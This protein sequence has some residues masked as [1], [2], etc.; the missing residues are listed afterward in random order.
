VVRNKSARSEPLSI[1]PKQL[2]EDDEAGVGRPRALNPMA[3]DDDD[4]DDDDV[5]IV[6]ILLCESIASLRFVGGR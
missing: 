5:L 4:D 6:L 1:G 2:T 3:N